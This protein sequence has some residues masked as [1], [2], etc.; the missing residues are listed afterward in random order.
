MKNLKRVF[1]NT[2]FFILLIILGCNKTIK[3]K[4]YYDTGELYSIIEVDKNEIRNGVTLV[5]FKNGNLREKARYKNGEFIDTSYHYR[6]DGSL[7]NIA[8]YNKSKD[9]IYAFFYDELGRVNKETITYKNNNKVG[10]IIA[11]DLINSLKYTHDVKNVY[12]KEIYYDNQVVLNQ[13][14]DTVKEK[15]FYYRVSVPDTVKVNDYVV[16]K[17]DFH[18]DLEMR[19][20]L[21]K[22]RLYLKIMVN[23]K[24]NEDFSNIN[25]VKLDTFIRKDNHFLLKF[26]D[27]GNQNVRGKFTERITIAQMDEENDEKVNVKD[28]VRDF[29]FNAPIYI[30]DTVK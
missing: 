23:E 1:K 28:Y 30:K 15:S 22:S 29:Y 14:G 12:G 6:E 18:S 4:N 10:R 17:I 27:T 19:E 2:Y 25:E 20:N 7:N 11:Y 9:S 8:I 21:L 5:Y 26:L 13:S 24:L 3:E 16:G